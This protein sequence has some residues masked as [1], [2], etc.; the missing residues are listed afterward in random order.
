MSVRS[1]SRAVLPTMAVS[2]TLIPSVA[3]MMTSLD[4]VAVDAGL[5]RRVDA[6]RT[7]N[8]FCTTWKL[9]T[10]TLPGRNGAAFRRTPYPPASN[11]SGT[12]SAPV[13]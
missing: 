5:S 6:G 7:C 13:V 9:E 3:S 12:L 4:G 1:R 8:G 11:W 10:A 2:P